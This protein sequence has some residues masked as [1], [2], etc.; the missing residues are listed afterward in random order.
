MGLALKHE[1]PN[2][3]RLRASQMGP[4]ANSIRL[5]R[6]KVGRAVSPA[7]G[8]GP[9]PREPHGWHLPLLPIWAQTIIKT[10]MSIHFVPGEKIVWASRL[11]AT[12]A[13]IGISFCGH[14]LEALSLFLTATNILSWM[15]VIIY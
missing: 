13:Y 15:A 2:S 11:Q 1:L 12:G 7:G 9:T 4:T 3:I 14:G 8:A 10:A 6:S 5:P